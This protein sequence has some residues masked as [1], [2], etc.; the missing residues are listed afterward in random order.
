MVSCFCKMLFC[1]CLEKHFEP[2]KWGNKKA[3]AQRSAVKPYKN[4][5]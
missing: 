2:I 4:V 3:A 5:F 1:K